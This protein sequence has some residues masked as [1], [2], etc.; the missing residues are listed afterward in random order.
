[1]RF[2][3]DAASFPREQMPTARRLRFESKWLQDSLVSSFS[4]VSDELELADVA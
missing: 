2:S 1:M 3:D 4:P